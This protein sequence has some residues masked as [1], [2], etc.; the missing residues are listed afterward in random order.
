[1]KPV[2]LMLVSRPTPKG[3]GAVE[4][5]DSRP[6]APAR[7]P[8]PATAAEGAAG[9][10][11]SPAAT[12]GRPAAAEG[13]VWRVVL[14]TGADCACMGVSERAAFRRTWHADRLLPSRLGGGWVLIRYFR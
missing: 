6:K 14:E 3:T 8:T 7:Q 4:A 2:A 11:S 12:S 1:M 13:D 5:L 9:S 10:D